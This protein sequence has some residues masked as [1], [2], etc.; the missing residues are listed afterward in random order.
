MKKLVYSLFT[1]AICTYSFAQ[2]AGGPDTYGYAWKSSNHTISPPTFKWVDISTRGTQVIGLGDDN[3]IGPFNFSTPF[4]YYWYDVTKLWIGSN[5]YITFYGDNIASPFPAS[6]PLSA[7]ANNWIAPLLADLNFS[8]TGNPGK[9]YYFANSDSIVV[10]FIDVPFWVN[11]T[12]PYTGQNTFQIILSRLDTSITFNYLITNKGTL[13]TMDN[14][15]G[16]ENSTGSIGLQVYIDALPPDTQAVK[17]YYP[18]VVSY[19]VTDAGIVWNDNNKNGGIF[20]KKGSSAYSLKCNIKNYGNQ[21]IGSF[22]AKDSV[23]N[24]SNVLVSTGSKSVASLAVGKDSLVTFNNTFSPSTTG[25]YSFISNISGITND[26]VASNNRLIQEIIVIDTSQ[27]TI[28]LDYSD[29]V[30][31]GGLGW[32]GGN[33]G[34]AEYFIPPFYPCKIVSTRFYITANATPAVGF[35]AK[36]YDDKGINGSKGNLLDSVYV[37]PSSITLNTFIT[38]NTAS[39]NLKITSGG[40]YLYWEMGGAGINLGR[41]NTPPISRRTYEV[42]LGSWAEY[43]SLLIEDFLMGINIEYTIPIADFSADSTADP[44]IDFT[45]K[46]TNN[47]T[48]WQW[49]FG[50]ATYSTAQNPSHTYSIN[51]KYKVCLTA[52]NNDGSTKACKFITID[53]NPPVADFVFDTISDPTIA[54]TDLSSNLPTSWYWDFDDFGNKSTAKNPTYKFKKSG[55]HKVCLDAVNAGGSDQICKN[56][57]IKYGAP[58]ADFSFNNT[59]EP[60]ISFTDKSKYSPTSWLWEFNDN[61][62]TSTTQNPVYTFSKNGTY[63]ICLTSTNSSGADSICKSITINK[64]KPVAKIAVDSN[65]DPLIKFFDN[66]SNIPTSWLWDFGEAGA[67]SILKNPQY[68]YI[69]NGIHKVCLKVTNAGGSDSTCIYIEVKNVPPVANFSFN[70]S[71]DPEIQF[72]DNSTNVPT[73]WYWDFDDNYVTSIKQNPS[74][75]FTTNGIHKVCLIAS[76]AGGKDTFCQNIVINN[77]PPKASFS[78]SNVNDPTVSFT[79]KSINNPTSWLWSFDDN[80]STST[81]QHPVYTF[82]N[83][84]THKICLKVSNGGGSDSFCTNL[85]IRKVKPEA[86]FSIDTSGDPKIVF[87]DLS[88]NIPQSWYWTFDDK[89]AYSILQNP[90]HFFSKNGSFNICLTATNAGGD[91]TYCKKIN[92][93]K[94]LPKA[95]FSVDSGNEPEIKFFDKSTNIPK[96]WLWTFDEYGAT[97]V[98]QNPMYKF[99]ENTHHQVCLK[100]SNLGGSDSVCKSIVISKALPKADFS[101]DLTA[102]PSVSFTDISIG[103]PVL[104]SWHFDDKGVDSS[105]IKNPVYIF[106]TDGIHQVCL[107]VKNTAGYSTPECKSISITGASVEFVEGFSHIITYPNPMVNSAVIYYKPLSSLENLNIRCFNTAGTQVKI[108]WQFHENYLQI[109]RSDLPTGLYML[110]ISDRQN[111]VFNVKLIID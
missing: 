106:R 78:L 103:S 25:T 71:N 56:I 98:L 8:G 27:K 11:S 23:I 110:Q 76:N 26:I 57:Y 39:S 1:L 94:N 101:Y 66:S 42:L 14:A 20:L 84:G 87:T 88:K 35:Y 49:D 73:S 69:V 55:W 15:V 16:I 19:Q 47:P 21:N 95:D 65:S 75:K 48:S 58:K 68:T 53:K 18:A 13:T 22:T 52:T 43:R 51:G 60:Q 64:W 36:I 45:D 54:F 28:T 31:N 104:W 72:A 9:C 107:I 67:T 97:S 81:L 74:Y 7:G 99:K 63:T 111:I 38:V 2:T 17:F 85:L 46:T 10:S 90:E 30:S 89:G 82:K 50:D 6:I 70:S 32:N 108:Q 83:N 80:G 12:T 93:F 4:H 79:D 40:I 5:G 41:D 34:I 91:H 29:G 102:M 96:S 37:A 86:L 44:K 24:F 62:N 33:G 109:Y 3:V 77:V 100:V 105:D 59:L 61:N 92:V